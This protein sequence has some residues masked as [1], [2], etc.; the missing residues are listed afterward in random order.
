[1]QSARYKLLQIVI[2]IGLVCL[3]G[4]FF[5]STSLEHAGNVLKY[6]VINY[7]GSFNVIQILDR[8]QI[9]PFNLLIDLILALLIIGVQIALDTKGKNYAELVQIPDLLPTWSRWLLYYAIAFGI[10]LL[11][12]FT[13]STFVYFQ[14]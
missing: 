7:Q 9:S 11:G 14:F 10:L 8:L 5:R 2:N 3:I 4:V 6:L 1:L 13:G 12:V